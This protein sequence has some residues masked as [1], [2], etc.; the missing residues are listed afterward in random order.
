MKKSIFNISKLSLI[1]VLGSWFMS[2][3]TPK[4]IGA[5]EWYLSQENAETL[6]SQGTL[7]TL[8]EFKDKY[9]TEEGNYCPDTLYRQRSKAG[10]YYLFSYTRSCY[11]KTYYR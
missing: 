1:L 5:D 8:Q 10:N 2:A 7:L 3:C 11:R 4:P 9:M 6:I